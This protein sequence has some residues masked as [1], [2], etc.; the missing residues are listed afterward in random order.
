[1]L[2]LEHVAADLLKLLIMKKMNILLVIIKI[3]VI[4]V[5]NYQM[6]FIR[7]KYILVQMY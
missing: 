6:Q 1:M 5:N 7:P 2:F 3:F 4:Y